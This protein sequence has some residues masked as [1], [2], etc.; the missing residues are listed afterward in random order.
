MKDGSWNNGHGLHMQPDATS[1]FPWY[2]AVPFALLLV[3]A[4]LRILNGNARAM[5]TLPCKVANPPVSLTSL[6]SSP[7]EAQRMRDAHQEAKCRGQGRGECRFRLKDGTFSPVRLSFHCLDAHLGWCMVTIEDITAGLSTSEEMLRLQNL[8]IMGKIACG[9]GHDLANLMMVVGY[10]LSRIDRAGSHD[11]EF[12]RQVKETVRAA[13]LAQEL[14]RRLVNLGREHR[15]QARAVDVNVAVRSAMSLLSG[16]LGKR[17][18]TSISCPAAPIMVWCDPV[19]LEQILLNLILNAR[20]AIPDVGRVLVKVRLCEVPTPDESGHSPV[21]SRYASLCIEDDGCGMTDEVQT[22]I[23]EPF[24]TTRHN[25]A[26]LGLT[27]VKSA[28][29]EI[30][31][32]MRIVSQLGTGTT[33]EVLLPVSATDQ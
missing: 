2:D 23:F 12:T 13:D 33:M 17:I 5:K 14:A 7:E 22:R 6:L 9:I 8:S 26:G 11:G 21:T 32:L 4:E 25:G 19:Q 20:E 18:K 15:S 1:L 16:V 28:V 3:D 31:G 29:D 30:G 24:Y 10:R 27:V